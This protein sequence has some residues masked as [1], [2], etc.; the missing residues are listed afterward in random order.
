MFGSQLDDPPP[1]PPY[2][3]D[4]GS[5]E[6]DTFA[7]EVAALSKAEG[8]SRKAGVKDAVGKLRA[9]VMKNR[10]ALNPQV[11]RLAPILE[12]LVDQSGLSNTLTGELRLIRR[13]CLRL[14]LEARLEDSEMEDGEDPSDIF[15]ALETR[16]LALAKFKT[17][18]EDLS[19]SSS[20]VD[21]EQFV[22]PDSE[23]RPGF[24]PRPISSDASDDESDEEPIDVDAFEGPEPTTISSGESEG[25]A[26]PRKP[27]PRP[28]RIKI[29]PGT[30]EVPAADSNESGDMPVG[31]TPKGVLKDSK[32]AFLSFEAPCSSCK[33]ASECVFESP[34]HLRCIPCSQKRG[35]CRWV[36]SEGSIGVNRR[37][38]VKRIGQG[39]SQTVC[40][41]FDGRTIHLKDEKAKDDARALLAEL[42]K[43][44]VTNANRLAAKTGPKA[45]TAF[46]IEVARPTASTVAS[47][48]LRSSS[49]SRESSR[50]VSFAA[51]PSPTPSVRSSSQSISRTSSSALSPLASP[52]L[53][54]PASSKPSST[55]SKLSPAQLVDL[56]AIRERLVIE[57]RRLLQSAAAIINEVAAEESITDLPVGTS[58]PDCRIPNLDDLS[59]DL[60][61]VRALL[62][63][64]KGK[65]VE[66]S[67][68]RKRSSN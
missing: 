27:A 66:G 21:T 55:S 46:R 2:V 49:S 13:L 26:T 48:H 1:A 45:L 60:D 54:P 18:L 33:N 8:D 28:R 52:S 44:T 32:D 50:S 7:E 22:F 38:E 62:P 59:I 43:F 36:S 57:H 24:Y 56:G 11:V 58:L 10:D 16:R 47:T 20:L 61:A 42:P 68:K 64:G 63:K 34:D 53:G 39:A 19:K 15:E 35:T 41:L 23:L 5:S 30:S 29:E 3:L 6:L 14:V 25:S 65:E 51:G 9:Y 37:G 12:D 31:K 4:A 67:K 40:G 17:A